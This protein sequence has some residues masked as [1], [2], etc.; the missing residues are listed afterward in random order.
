MTL[1]DENGRSLDIQA[2]EPGLQQLSQ[3]AAPDPDRWIRPDR[4]EADVGGDVRWRGDDHVRQLIRLGVLGAQF[5]C[6]LV[7]VDGPHPSRWC[8]CGQRAGDRPVPAPEVEQL[9]LL[10]CGRAELQKQLRASVDRSAREDPAIRRQLEG[11]ADVVEP[12]RNMPWTA[13]H[14][15]PYVEVLGHAQ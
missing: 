8:S 13:G 14:T 1:H 3:S 15:R 11:L 5:S 9:T 6:P 10:R 7:H 2:H 4:L 12:Q